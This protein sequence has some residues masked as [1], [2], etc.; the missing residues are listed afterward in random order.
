MAKKTSTEGRSLPQELQ[1]G[2]R[3]RPYL[4][5]GSKETAILQQA[6][7]F[8]VSILYLARI[9]GQAPALTQEKFKAE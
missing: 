1:V 4:L 9:F 6:C 8:V 2:P 3:S 5:V 7:F